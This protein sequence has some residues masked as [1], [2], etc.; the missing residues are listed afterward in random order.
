MDGRIRHQIE[1]R[2]KAAR[3]FDA[4]FGYSAIATRLRLPAGTLR[5][6]QDAH[7]QGRLLGLAVM[8][9]NKHYSPEAKLTAVEKFLAG[10]IKAE[11]IDE[12]Q[13]SSRSL[14]NKWLAIYRS[15][16]AQG[17]TG[18]PKGRP[19]RGV[20]QSQE[21]LEAKVYR[22]EMENAVL[23]KFHALMAKEEAAP[24][25]KRRQ[26]RRESTISRFRIYVGLLAYQLAL[27]TTTATRFTLLTLTWPFARLFVKYSTTPTAVTVTDGSGRC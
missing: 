12:F 20:D 11:V 22:L 27:S 14:F 1:T 8:A 26:S 18:K 16:G 17:L 25:A 2:I 7:R 24:K 3:L 19:K 4:G 21:T 23:K 5:N 9:E 13:I 6:W 15:E 10:T